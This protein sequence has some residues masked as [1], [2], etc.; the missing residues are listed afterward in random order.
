MSSAPN[1]VYATKKRINYTNAQK[2]G[3]LCRYR[4]PSVML[5]CSVAV[6]P[7]EMS[8]VGSPRLAVRSVAARAVRGLVSVVVTTPI[9]I[10]VKHCT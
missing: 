1:F 10:K 6:L 4:T 2:G 5:C 8:S 7:S 3:R 9:T